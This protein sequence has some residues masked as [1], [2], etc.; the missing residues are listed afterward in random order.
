[1]APAI[2]PN[3]DTQVMLITS[4]SHLIHNQ[5][6]YEHCYT[7]SHAHPAKTSFCMNRLETSNL[8]L[9]EGLHVHVMWY[10][11]AHIEFDYV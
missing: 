1:M 6:E 9:Q 5:I 3:H 2:M 7:T 11:N 4:Y 8:V 10:S